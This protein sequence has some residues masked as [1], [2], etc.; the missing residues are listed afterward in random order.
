MKIRQPKIETRDISELREWDDNPRV[1]T[2][3]DIE[4]LKR[5]IKKLGQYKPLIVEPDGLVIG[6]NMRLKALRDLGA[7]TV[8]VSVVE[9]KDASQRMEFAL[10]DNDRIGR[11]EESSLT[12]MLEPLELDMADFGIDISQPMSLPNLMEPME[13]PGEAEDEKQEI[14]EAKM[15]GKK[16][17]KLVYGDE[18]YM[19]V[20][21]LLAQVK[22]DL[23]IDDDADAVRQCLITYVRKT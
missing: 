16:S 2:E 13:L 5:Q 10:S 6:G 14:K 3:A 20:L 1:A 7:E 18:D 9:P 12:G 8:C 11:Y 15:D 17:L 23:G 4:R 22:A 19:E 21:E